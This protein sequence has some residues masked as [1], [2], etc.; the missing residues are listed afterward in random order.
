MQRILFLGLIA[1]I[2]IAILYACNSGRNSAAP[3]TTSLSGGDLPALGLSVQEQS[4]TFNTVGQTINY[5]Y[6]VTNT[7]STAL[8]GPVTV[9]DDKVAVTCAD[10]NTVGNQNSNLVP[11][12]SVTCASTYALTQGDLNSGSVT[13]NATA[14]AGGINSNSP[15]SGTAPKVT[16][17]DP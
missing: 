15:D 13:N 17:S 4:G 14:S 1:I 3:E 2:L 7:G 8:V 6:I 16:S 5:Q 9:T 11:T 12:E 10:V